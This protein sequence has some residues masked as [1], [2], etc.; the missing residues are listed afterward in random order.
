MVDAELR[1]AQP[2]E[3]GLGVVGAGAILALVLHRVVD[4]EGFEP[5]VKIVPGVALISVD[6]GSLA[7]RALYEAGGLVLAAEDLRLAATAALGDDHHHLALAALVLL[8][9]PVDAV[10]LAVR[11][12]T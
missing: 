6:G 9:P 4:P 12:R 3:I 1:P 7:E 5:A 2:G 11:G 8:E 10:L